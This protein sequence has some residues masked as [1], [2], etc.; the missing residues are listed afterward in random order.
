M[1]VEV[2]KTR[3]LVLCDQP[4]GKTSAFVTGG[5]YDFAA[6][7]TDRGGKAHRGGRLA[8]LNALQF[9]RYLFHHRGADQSARMMQG[10]SSAK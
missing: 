5:R 3:S 2:C 8:A 9:T 4:T 1:A 6:N 10:I 7:R